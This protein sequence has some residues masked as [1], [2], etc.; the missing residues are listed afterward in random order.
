[1]TIYRQHDETEVSEIYG[2]NCKKI[3]AIPSELKDVGH[4]FYFYIESIWLRV[5]INAELLFVDECDGPD[6]E[7]DLDGDEQYIDYSSE[8]TNTNANIKSA[9]M[10][11]DMFTIIFS[12]GLVITLSGTDGGTLIRVLHR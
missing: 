5:F 11:D 10:K 9:R 12:E 7:D 8:L 1:M 2:M 4:A 6:P 3:L